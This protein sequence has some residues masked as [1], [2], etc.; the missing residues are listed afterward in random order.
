MTANDIIEQL[1]EMGSESTKNIFIKHGA[2]EPFYGVKVQ[3]MKKIQKK[4][5]QDHELSLELFDSRI[6]DAMYLAGLIAEPQKMTKA[7]LNK[8]AKNANWYMVSEYTVA[9]VAAESNYG[10]ELAL[11][12]IESDKEHIASAGWSTLSSIVAIKQDNELDI[13][14]L[15]Q[16]I[17]RVVKT[18]HSSHNRV[19]YTMNG[20]VIAVGS[21]VKELT[22]VAI[23]AGEKI[24]KVDVEMGGTACKVPPVVLYIE[25]VQSKGY[26]G[27][28]RKRAVC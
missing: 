15:K 27:K 16:L 20:F 2:K 23:K 5:K 7:Q 11:E 9:W 4:V 21:Y 18:I 1:K 28:K 14:T 17:G 26:I 22:N 13:K 6:G 24:G 10:W 25:K 19:R 12:W 3:D 8:W